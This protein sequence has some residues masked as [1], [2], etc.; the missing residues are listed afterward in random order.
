MKKTKLILSGT[1]ILLALTSF[2]FAG[3][4]YKEALRQTS[5]AKEVEHK[6]QDGNKQEM[7]QQEELKQADKDVK[8]E[9][10]LRTFPQRSSKAGY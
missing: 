10:I 2:A 8:A 7:F 5:E 9:K 1:G 6:T 3:S 4:M